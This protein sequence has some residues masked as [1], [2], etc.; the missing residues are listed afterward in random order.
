VVSEPRPD[1]LEAGHIAGQ[2][3]NTP[4]R[5]PRH[6]AYYTRRSPKDFLQRNKLAI[7]TVVVL[8]ALLGWAIWTTVQKW[9]SVEGSIGTHERQRLLGTE[10]PT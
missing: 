8:L 7:F 2:N 4:E 10:D 5:M 9:P 3:P 6:T 1:P